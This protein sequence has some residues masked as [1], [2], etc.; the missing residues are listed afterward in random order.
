MR[1]EDM[2][3]RVRDQVTPAP[4]RTLA[5]LSRIPRDSGRGAAV[6]AR[7]VRKDYPA[8]RQASIAWLQS[9]SQPSDSAF[10][11]DLKPPFG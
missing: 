8:P 1:R 11:S 6:S 3:P 10:E 9:R 2:R 4:Y 5:D 7:I